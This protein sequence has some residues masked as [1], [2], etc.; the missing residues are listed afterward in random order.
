MVENIFTN[1]VIATHA[2]VRGGGATLNGK[3][4]IRYQQTNDLSVPKTAGFVSLNS[5]SCSTTTSFAPTALLKDFVVG[6]SHPQHWVKV[7]YRLWT[8]LIKKCNSH[9]TLNLF[10]K[11]NSD[12]S[13]TLT[14][15]ALS[16]A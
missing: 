15:L 10:I 12:L 11:Q 7:R 3:S 6:F 1:S 2:S 13:L 14:F 16:P 4:Q 9:F 5:Q 8:G